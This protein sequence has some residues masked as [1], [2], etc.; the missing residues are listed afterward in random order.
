MALVFDSSGNL[1]VANNGNT[2]SASSH[3]EHDADLTLTGL[4]GPHGLAFDSSA[5][6]TWPILRRHRQRVRAGSSTPA[7][8]LTGLM[9]PGLVFDSSGNLYV[10]NL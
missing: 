1:Y 2:R 5:T 9:L 7:S 6:S 8:T 3:R 10:A 4:V